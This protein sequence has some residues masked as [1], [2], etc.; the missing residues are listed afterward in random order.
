MPGR[1]SGTGLPFVAVGVMFEDLAPLTV[2][3]APA[4]HAHEPIDLE[5]RLLGG[6]TAT[7]WLQQWAIGTSGL[8]WYDVTL[9]VE[10]LAH[11]AAPP[12]LGLWLWLRHRERFDRF[13]GA[14]VLMMAV[15]SAVYFGYPQAPPGWPHAQASCFRSAGS[16]SMS[17]TMS[18]G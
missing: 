15:G 17:S 4:V 3:I 14:Y 10:Y 7:T 9:A 13:V 11:F 12:A 6:T 16:W 1:S 5:R 2:P 18:G 8:D